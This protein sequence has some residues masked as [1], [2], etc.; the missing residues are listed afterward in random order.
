[1]RPLT[2]L[3]V[4]FSLSLTA[5][6]AAW[7]GAGHGGPDH[8]SA[9][10][11]HQDHHNGHPRRSAGLNPPGWHR[12]DRLPDG[13]RDHRHTVYEWHAHRLPPP[14]RHHRWVSV[15]GDYL[16]IAIASGVILSVVAA[17]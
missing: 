7:A 3:V 13:Y 11:H 8:H 9:R 17:H 2:A 6:P 4:A 10:A 14:D 16:L 15:N 1:M 12:G 5:A